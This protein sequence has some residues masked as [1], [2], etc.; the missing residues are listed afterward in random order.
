MSFCCSY[1]L[2]AYV[3]R[4]S[5]G[6][7]LAFD[8]RAGEMSEECETKKVDIMRADMDATTCE[9]RNQ[10]SNGRVQ[11]QLLYLSRLLRFNFR[12]LGMPEDTKQ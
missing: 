11:R 2:N 7:T 8:A 9:G 10:Y 12:V 5:D 3:A 4:L 6:S 1:V